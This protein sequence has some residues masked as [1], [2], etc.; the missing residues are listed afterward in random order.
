[1]PT[2]AEAGS[3]HVSI[4]IYQ[5]GMINRGELIAKTVEINRGESVSCE[6]PLRFDYGVP[7]FQTTL[8][9]SGDVI[10]KALTVEEL[11]DDLS[12]ANI[13]VLEG[14]LKEI[15]AI[16]DPRKSDYPDCRFT[17][18]LEGAVIIDGVPCQRQIQLAI[19]GFKNYGLLA[20]AKLKPGDK[21]RCAVV[22]F[23]KLPEEKKT[24]QL[25]DDLNIFDLPLFYA[26][27][28]SRLVSFSEASAIPF[29]DKVEY[30]SV[31]KRKINP[32]L[33]DDTKS[34]QHKAI[35]DSLAWMD[36]KLAPY[37]TSGELKKL[38]ARFVHVWKAEKNKDPSGRN[39]CGDNKNFVWRNIDNSFW[40]LPV[41]YGALAP[42]AIVLDRDKLDALLALQDFLNAN[43]CQ[44]LIGIVPDL[45]AISARVI[46]R[47]FVNVPDFGSAWLVRQLLGNGLEAVYISDRLLKEYNRHQF[48]FFWPNNAHPSDT[49]QDIL[50]DVFSERLQ[51]Y[52]FKKTLDGNLFTTDAFPHAYSKKKTYLFPEN[53]DIGS[54]QAGTP[55]R[56]RRVLYGGKEI[57]PD[58]QSP[59]L[60][61]GNSFIQTPMS[62]PNS[63]PT[64]LA[65]KMH[66]GIDSYR[67]DGSG[68]MTSGIGQLFSNP[69]KYLRGKRVMIL[70]LGVSHF[71]IPRFTN[72]REIDRQMLQLAGKMP[73]ETIPVFG[74][75]NNVPVCFK[76]LGKAKYFT[77][78]DI[79]KQLVVDQPLPRNH[80]EAMLVIPI[81]ANY[82]H[83]AELNI[84]GEKF[85]IPGSFAIYHWNRIVAPIPKDAE[86]LT[87][88]LV[89][90]PGATVAL[91]DIQIFK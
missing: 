61:W 47:E 30:T 51:R 38:D 56:C 81:C 8:K 84:N 17:A 9:I 27:E 11:P 34:M 50:A 3:S 58:P 49:T 1:M 7:Q 36:K 19:D 73:A 90:K 41:N 42:K 46:N 57:F 29:A 25:A 77:I 83:P 54:N 67:L 86:R 23:E 55:Y 43:G 31:F 39:R 75:E 68:P 12:M 32:P 76:N 4:G 82:S 22:P 33:S 20:T 59:I 69:E 74:N 10:L 15:S 91:G 62:Y 37:S 60:V 6:V 35:A 70:I 48:A 85:A 87:I 89:G 80:R 64:L 79:G 78:P 26:L 52:G 13:T 45:F 2:D 18:S 63:F 16:P 44:L 53:C 88:E 14:T 40:V 24:V 28:M 21:I 71:N 66:M 5:S 72:I 65:S